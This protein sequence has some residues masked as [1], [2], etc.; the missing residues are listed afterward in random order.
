MFM[1][2]LRRQS[3]RKVFDRARA[4]KVITTF[5]IIVA[6]VAIRWVY[7]SF[8]GGSAEMRY[9]LS[10]VT[11]GTVISSISGTGQVAASN[12]VEVKSKASGDVISIAVDNGQSV[13]AGA[14]IASLDVRD[15]EKAVRDAEAN[16]QSAELSLEKLK[17]PA[18]QLSLTQ[19]KNALDR[20]Y[21]S[22]QNAE[23]DL[24][25]SYDDGFNTVSS[26]FL[27]LP[28]IIT[29]LHDV[30]FG[31]ASG[32][33]TGGQANIDY[34]TDT[35]K[36]YDD[37][38]T[39]YRADA[40]NAYNAA[41]GA[42]DSALTAYKATSRTS[43]TSTIESLIGTTYDTTRDIAEA[44]K[45]G[46]NLVQFYKDTLTNQNKT[47]SSVADTHL[48]TLNT[49]T[50]KTN[51]HLTNLLSSK[52]T[53]QSDKDAIRNASRTID[54]NTQSLSKLEAGTDE[55]DIKS[56]EL[57]VLQR[58][59]ALA[60]AREK[61]ADSYVRAPF[62]GTIA[63][64][65]VK[66]SDSISSGTSIA[67]I[68]T[69]QKLAEISLNE[70]DAAKI[71]VGDKATLT[72]DAIDGLSL[73]GSV[74]EIDTVGSV[75]QGVVTYMV[76]I[77]FDTED[78]RVKPGMSVSAGIII[79]SKQDVLTVENSAI[80]NQGNSSYVEILDI[81]KGTEITSDGVASPVAPRQ[82]AI[83]A[84]I[85]SDTLTEVR[86]GLVEGQYVVVRTITSSAGSSQAQQAPSLFGGG[87]A[88]GG[89]AV[90]I[91]R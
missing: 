48:A 41:H 85:S 82:Q 43:S 42:Y 30:L 36:A 23:D 77:G 16:L 54:E 87:R 26:A 59:N 25:K 2:I 18:D 17:K 89:G 63:K 80:K 40:V 33:G 10:Q 84:G 81:P 71:S 62:D 47:P 55:L 53:I 61:L 37:R 27:D 60:D 28:D 65:N 44:V 7:A 57:T 75:S 66:K 31:H 45:S 34:Y 3:I 86:S 12:Q 35:A 9:V 5:S 38:A 39:A 6:L 68:I 22:K 14:L 78:S 51:T 4:H 19:S 46:N 1:K 70:V 15:A 69:H 83:E 11:R 74:A 20:A 13:K 56:A 72:F 8:L 73:T 64:V 32:L 52:N 49:Y 21:E 90:R 50:G 79:D 24:A 91:S 29:G 67:T 88:G 76:K 58:Q